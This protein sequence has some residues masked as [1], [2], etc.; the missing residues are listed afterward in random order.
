MQRE[1]TK[2]GERLGGGKIRG[3]IIENSDDK[4]E[5]INHV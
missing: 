3:L 4:T 5:Y 2:R 1:Q